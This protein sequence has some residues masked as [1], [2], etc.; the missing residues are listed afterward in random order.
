M[1][2]EQKKSLYSTWLV[3]TLC[4]VI[5]LAVINAVLFNVALADISGELSIGP[6][7]VSWI[8][9]GYSMMVAI[10][11]I[12]YGKLADRFRVKSL[13]IFAL[14][15]FLAGSL[16]GFG[17]SSFAAVII[18]RIIQ[19]SGGSAFISLSMISVAR[20]LQPEKRPGALA[21]FSATI[22]LAAGIG[23]LVGG[24]VTHTLGW[25]YLFLLMVIAI[26]AIALL[27]KF[28]PKEEQQQSP[29][30]L[31]FDFAG[32]ALLFGVIVAVLFAVNLNGLFFLL[33]LAFAFGFKWWLPRTSA[34]FVER[35]LFANQAY[36]RLIGIGFLMNVGA[37]ANMFLAPLYLIHVHKLSPFVVGLLLFL[38]G[39]SGVL[40][41]F[42]SGKLLPRVGGGKIIFAATVMMMTGFLAMGVIPRP[43]IIVVTILLLLTMMSY[44]AIQVSLNN[45]VPRT[46]LPSKIG[47]GLGFYNLLN[48]V[49]MAF[50]PAAASRLFEKTGNYSL[51]F[52]GMAV[53]ICL[54]F[55]LVAKPAA[56]QQQS[57]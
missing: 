31:P 11:S 3:L 22:A 32:A 12:T 53:V 17:F 25:R 37:M 49:G 40:S 52:L 9:V 21:M 47:V 1:M 10:G 57:H 18:G 6:S 46:L 34:P 33:A 42:A 13:L 35:D 16:I 44:S 54:H 41:S 45:L 43:D 39:I 56:V 55:L 28:M 36:L 2:L 14:V 4:F 51:I 23:P 27:I 30:S 7:Q 48:F 26:V 38:G 29:A 5:M 8:V 20:F 24:A 19:A 15:L 50:G